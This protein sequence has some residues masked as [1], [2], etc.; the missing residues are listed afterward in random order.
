MKKLF[1]LM[2]LIVIVACKNDKETI[3]DQVGADSTTSALDSIQ[4]PTFQDPEVDGPFKIIPQNITS[5][6]GRAIFTQNG[7]VLF[8]F[9][10]NANEGMISIGNKQYA[11]DRF[12]F[13]ENN[14]KISGESVMIDAANGDFQDGSGDCIAGSFAQIKVVV[15]NETLNLANIEVQDCPNY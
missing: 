9:D 4:I 10:Q 2:V 15:N 5:K 12:D 3:T 6:K 7:K 11:L 8:Y 14:Y 1:L 13:T